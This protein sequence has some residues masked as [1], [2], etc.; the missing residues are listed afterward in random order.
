MPLM[1]YVVC[2]R[3]FISAPFCPSYTCKFCLSDGLC[4]TLERGFLNRLLEAGA[5][6]SSG[7]S[8]SCHLGNDV[9]PEQS[10]TVNVLQ[11]IFLP[12]SDQWHMNNEFV[13]AALT[14]LPENGSFC[15]IFSFVV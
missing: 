7:Y 14:K 13:S 8:P 9:P 1:F 5:T 3:C 15:S 6:E 11:K 10:S 12:S 4:M 2:F